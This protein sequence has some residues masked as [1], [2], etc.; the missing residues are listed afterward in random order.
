MAFYK[1]RWALAFALSALVSYPYGNNIT[2]FPINDR[3]RPLPQAVTKNLDNQ[4]DCCS[5]SGVMALYNYWCFTK[6]VLSALNLPSKRLIGRFFKNL[7]FI[8][9][10]NS[11]QLNNF[12]GGWVFGLKLVRVLVL[13]WVLTTT[14]MPPL[15]KGSKTRSL[16]QIF[17]KFMGKYPLQS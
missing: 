13:D 1:N 10:L 7:F 5:H 2:Y 9:F 3:L 15:W 17:E 8:L 4:L 6:L 12:L 11:N 14:V 16:C